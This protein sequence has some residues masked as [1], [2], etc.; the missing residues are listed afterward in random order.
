[1]GQHYVLGKF[2]GLVSGFIN[3]VELRKAESSIQAKCFTE[4]RNE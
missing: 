1:M 2:W 3:L 4:E